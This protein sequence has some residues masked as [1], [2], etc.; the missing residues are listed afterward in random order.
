MDFYPLPGKCQ[1]PATGNRLAPVPDADYIR[2]FDGI[3]KTE[4]KNATVFRGAYAGDGV[5]PGW[6]LLSGIKAPNASSLIKL[7]SHSGVD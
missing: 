2:D 7:D 6:H 1:G 3:P 4:A 5:K